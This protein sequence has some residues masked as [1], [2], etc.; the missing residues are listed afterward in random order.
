MMSPNGD[1]SNKRQNNKEEKPS[2][3]LNPWLQ[4]L[5]ERVK[6]LT[7]RST[8]QASMPPLSSYPRQQLGH[9][10]EADSR[11]ATWVTE[12]SRL[13]SVLSR[14]I[15]M[16]LLSRVLDSV[17]RKPAFVPSVWQRML[18]LP[19]FRQNREQR[20]SSTATTGTAPEGKLTD[21]VSLQ[22]ERY[23]NTL[24]QA[25]R[26]AEEGRPGDDVVETY[27]LSA[28]A[29]PHA[30][31]SGSLPV[32]EEDTA[33][34]LHSNEVHREPDIIRDWPPVSPTDIAYPAVI[35]NL[36][37][38]PTAG[39]RMP[40]IT[41]ALFIAPMAG[42][43]EIAPEAQEADSFASSRARYGRTSKPDL[44]KS[45]DVRGPEPR[46]VNVAKEK[47][48]RV[49]RQPYHVHSERS[50]SRSLTPMTK[51]A[52]RQRE[53]VE[54]HPQDTTERISEGP[55]S[56]IRDFYYP[57]LANR[58]VGES[59]GFMLGKVDLP[60][61]T[62]VTDAPEEP[63]QLAMMATETKLGEPV[64]NPLPTREV[65]PGEVSRVPPYRVAPQRAPDVIQTRTGKPVISRAAKRAS[66][67]AEVTLKPEEDEPNLSPDV[68]SLV[69]GARSSMDKDL[70]GYAEKRFFYKETPVTAGSTIQR[71]PVI[72]SI[73]R[74]ITL[75]YQR[76]FRSVTDAYPFDKSKSGGLLVNR[77]Y[78]SPS[79]GYDYA[80]QPVLSLPVPSPKPPAD[81]RASHSEGLLG[82]ASDA[83]SDLIY[84][85]NNGTNTSGVIQRAPESTTSAAE[86]NEP[87]QVAAPE[88]GGEESGERGTTTDI[89]ALAREIYPLIKRMIMVERER[90]PI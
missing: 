53:T 14:A 64:L 59:I 3:E 36:F 5:A 35:H 2:K 83:V 38:S 8:V 89:R 84:S 62:N 4:R 46:Q 58:G 86:T 40:D 82:Q 7:A 90:R 54:A 6:P 29:S 23:P 56:P 72:K 79:T 34:T 43:V 60:L 67:E 12:H 76:L 74:K 87:T 19:W 1:I 77:E 11:L 37:P 20:R 69:T 81:I 44:H 13:A 70:E 33:D 15:H 42:E 41:R 31:H 30:A 80:R 78:V 24:I 26:D 50:L 17:W 68:L 88:L 47:I 49:Y 9:L 22:S 16:P 61:I 10:G 65:M 21:T 73:S 66:E 39:G 18:D 75:P 48:A 55:V 51:P 71:Q 28:V 32:G 25:I 63:G 57:K 85:R 52:T 27:P 45:S